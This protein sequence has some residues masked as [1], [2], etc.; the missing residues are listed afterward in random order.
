MAENIKIT[1]P[2]LILVEGKDDKYFF[3]YLMKHI[4]LEDCQVI[5]VE[6]KDNFSNVFKSIMLLPGFNTVNSLAFIRDADNDCRKSFNEIISII[7]SN[8]RSLIK[9]A[10][11]ISYPDKPGVFF[12]INNLKIGTFILPNNSNPG[13][14]EDICLNS[15]STRPAIECIDSYVQC[16]KSKLDRKTDEI[17]SNNSSNY[18]PKNESKMKMLVFLASLYEYSNNIGDAAQ[19]GS[20]DFNHSSFIELISFLKQL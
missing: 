14:I 11:T 2:K 19:K 3:Q 15:C 5:N 8:N 6:G 17:S 18:F 12:N 10:A 13:M 4:C 9:T 1:Q 16:L 7:K 20:W